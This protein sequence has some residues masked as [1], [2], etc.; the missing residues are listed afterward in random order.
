MYYEASKM[1]SIVIPKPTMVWLELIRIR[2]LHQDLIAFRAQV[3]TLTTM[4][5]HPYYSKWLR[6]RHVKNPYYWL[7]ITR[8]KERENYFIIQELFT[9]VE[10]FFLYKNI[11][12]QWIFVDSFIIWAFLH[13]LCCN[14][15]SM[16]KKDNSKQRYGTWIYWILIYKLPRLSLT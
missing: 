13:I 1:M 12:T 10:V 3:C 5:H 14:R 6:V 15:K 4:P 16:L 7:S 11:P 2:H 9:E 8:K